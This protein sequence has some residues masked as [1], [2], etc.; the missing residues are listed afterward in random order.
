MKRPIVLGL[1]LSAFASAG[2]FDPPAAPSGNALVTAVTEIF[3]GTLDAKGSASFTFVVGNPDPLRITLASVTNP[4]TGAAVTTAVQLDLGLKSGDDCKSTFSTKTSAALVSQ[5]FQV[6]TPGT[7]CVVV[8]DPGTLTFPLNFA[9]R[10][11]HS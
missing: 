3:Q 1:I 7:Y 2:C 5:Y 6:A 11:I 8:A 4:A 10:I 9:V